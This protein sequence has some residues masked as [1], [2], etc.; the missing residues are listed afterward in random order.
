MLIGDQTAEGAVVIYK[1]VMWRRQLL[2]DIMYFD[3]PLLI[4]GC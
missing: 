1:P 3:Q 2:N 4:C